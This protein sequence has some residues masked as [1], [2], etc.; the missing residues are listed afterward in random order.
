LQRLAVDA[1]VGRDGFLGGRR[2][3]TAAAGLTRP[4]GA[5]IGLVDRVATFTCDLTPPI[6]GQ[7][8][9]WITPVRTIEIRSWQG[10]RFGRRPRSLRVCTID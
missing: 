10:D 6:G 7:P 9:I 5:A 4:A 8:I 1:H 2:R 3:H